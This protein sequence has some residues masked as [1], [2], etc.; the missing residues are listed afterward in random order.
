MKRFL[1]K[2]LREHIREQLGPGLP[3]AAEIVRYRPI[4]RETRSTTLELAWL[5]TSVNVASVVLNV[6]VTLYL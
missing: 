5:L 1:Q 4:R 2:F 3:G 6:L